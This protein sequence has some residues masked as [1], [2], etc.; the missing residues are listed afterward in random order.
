MTTEREMLEAVVRMNAGASTED[1][2]ERAEAIRTKLTR[3]L[4]GQVAS[5]RAAEREKL[6]LELAE[7]LGV[8]ADIAEA[9]GWTSLTGM[10][11]GIR[12]IA[13]LVLGTAGGPE[14]DQGKRQELLTSFGVADYWAR[15]QV[16][17]AHIGPTY[18]EALGLDD[19]PDA[20]RSGGGR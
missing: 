17:A 14:L 3:A 9:H 11:L 16:T 2:A 6:T 4:A 20:A 15:V 8:P 1:I 19:G 13:D 10:V 12:A 18:R 7:A 5:A